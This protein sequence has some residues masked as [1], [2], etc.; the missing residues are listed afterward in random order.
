MKCPY[1]KENIL[2]GANKCKFCGE[3]LSFRFRF[4]NNSL[5]L[6]NILIPLLALLIAGWQTYSKSIVIKEK[7]QIEQEVILTQEILNEVPDEILN[8]MLI[9]EEEEIGLFI[10]EEEKPRELEQR[11]Q[12]IQKA[13][14]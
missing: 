12:I 11:K 1:C 9:F 7:S 6:F 4:I 5:V 2:D 13:L 10:T 14:R 8:Q 3:L